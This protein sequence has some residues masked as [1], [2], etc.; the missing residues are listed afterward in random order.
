MGVSGYVAPCRTEAQLL[1]AKSKLATATSRATKAKA[2][3]S[4]GKI[5]DAFYWWNLLFDGKFPSYYR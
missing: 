1:D 3:E 2:A 4:D 5:K